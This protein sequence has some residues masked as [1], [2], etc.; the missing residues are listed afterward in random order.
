MAWHQL[1]MPAPPADYGVLMVYNTG[2]P[3]NFAPRN[4]ILDIRDVQ[5]YM[6]YLADYPLPLAAAYPVY[7]WQRTIGGVRI[8]HSVEAKEIIAA[9]RMIEHERPDMGNTIVIYSLDKENI[10]RYDNETFR[11]IYGR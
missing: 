7:R 11:E 10:N 2:D 6:R 5:P 8:A 9:K 4:P 1:S 3:K